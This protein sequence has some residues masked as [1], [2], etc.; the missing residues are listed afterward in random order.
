MPTSLRE[1]PSDRPVFDPSTR[2]PAIPSQVPS[3][4]DGDG[5]FDSKAQTEDFDA[6]NRLGV[7][8]KGGNA[9]SRPL[10]LSFNRPE[11]NHVSILQKSRRG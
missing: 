5:D 1:N 7:L 8:G 9:S 3:D 2:M 6:H 4:P 11:P 10:G